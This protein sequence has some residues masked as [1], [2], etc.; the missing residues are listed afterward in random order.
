MLWPV[1]QTLLASICTGSDAALVC[2]WGALVC[3][4]IGHRLTR[5]TTLEKRQ[6]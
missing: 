6:N 3:D 2:R 4:Y 5:I 1:A